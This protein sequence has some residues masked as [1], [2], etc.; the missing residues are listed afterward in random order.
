MKKVFLLQM[1]LIVFS[2]G[3]LNAQTL[4]YSNS[5]YAIEDVI[6][7]RIAD[8]MGVQP[9][10]PGS[11]VTWDFSNLFID[12][13]IRTNTCVDPKATLYADSFPLSNVA[14]L[15]NTGSYTFYKCDTS[16]CSLFGV[17][18]TSNMMIYS[19]PAVYFKYPISYGTQFSDSFMTDNMAFLTKG[20]Q[21]LHADGKGSIILAGQTFNNVLRIKSSNYTVM[22]SD[23]LTFIM[24]MVSYGWYDCIHKTPLLTINYLTMT[25][26]MGD[27]IK[28]KS[29]IVSNDIISGIEYNFHFTNN[30]L[31][32]YPNPATKN[33]TLEFNIENNHNPV[34]LQVVDLTGKIV[35]HRLIT[36]TVQGLNS[37]ILDIDKLQGG[38]YMVNLLQGNVLTQRKLVVY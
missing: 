23:F 4:N 19:D 27:T 3:F 5:G 10:N 26:S 36:N 8:T 9:G 24:D 15:D 21:K 16:E 35:S 38:V 22:S 37:L 13:E 32:L 1:M 2:F 11:N 34:M 29:V 25:T 18:D 14:V 12:T 33:V 28:G 31:G 6:S 30:T 20:E 7:T 17:A